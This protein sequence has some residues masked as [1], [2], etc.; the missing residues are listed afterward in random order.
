VRRFFSRVLTLSVI[1]GN[2]FLPLTQL[3]L[4]KKIEVELPNASTEVVY[5]A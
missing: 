3:E 2:V 4:G 5:G 1:P